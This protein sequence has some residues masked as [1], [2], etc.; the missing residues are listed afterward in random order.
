MAGPEALIGVAQ[1][2]GSPGFTSLWVTDR[3]LWQG[4]PQSSRRHR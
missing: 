2:G 1:R 4:F 3:L